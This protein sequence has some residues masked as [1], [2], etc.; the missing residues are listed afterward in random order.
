MYSLQQQRIFI[1]I[2]NI[3]MQDNASI[4]SAGEIPVNYHGKIASS[5]F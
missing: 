2:V 5:D 1:E 3:L 4:L